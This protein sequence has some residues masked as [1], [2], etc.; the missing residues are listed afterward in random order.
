L[1]EKI[2]TPEQTRDRAAFLADK[3]GQKQVDAR[4]LPDGRRYT[5]VGQFGT[6]VEY[7][8]AAPVST[9][10]HALRYGGE[11]R[12]VPQYQDLLHLELM[13]DGVYFVVVYPRP[14]TEKPPTFTTAGNGT[15]IKTV[16]A[17]GTDYAFLADDQ[18]SV[19]E[20]G[21]IRFTGTAASVQEHG[22]RT[23]LTL[24]AAGRV[25]A[26]DLVL[27]A[28]FAAHLTVAGE[29]MSLTLPTDNPGGQVTVVAP[30]TWK[31]RRAKG[32]KVKT[33]SDGMR[34][35]VPKGPC[36]VVFER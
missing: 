33:T 24:A 31:A 1:S 18:T 4:Q 16:H 2:G 25:T 14:Q 30:G 5:A 21:G 26:N 22:S 36:Q 8:V 15:I 11:Y 13:S 12:R 27:Q 29:N 35:A 3:P 23:H 9:V 19:T 17:F 7:Y 20:T 6:D 10:R 32:V 28:S 34:V